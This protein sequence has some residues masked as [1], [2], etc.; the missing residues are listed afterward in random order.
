MTPVKELIVNFNVYRNK[1]GI[2]PDNHVQFD[3][4]ISE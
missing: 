4:Y 3:E 1:Q 2:R